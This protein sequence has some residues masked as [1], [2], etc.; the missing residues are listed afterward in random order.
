MKC[1]WSVHVREKDG[2]VNSLRLNEGIEAYIC[3]PKYSFFVGVSVSLRQ[4]D[5]SG[6]PCDEE[7]SI[8]DELESLIVEQL[9]DNMLCVFTSVMTA[10]GSRD[11][12]MYTYAPQQ[13]EKILGVLNETWSH[14]D[15]QFVFQEDPDWDVFKILLD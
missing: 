7:K 13:C 11:Y 14:H 9:V 10:E 2:V 15:I 8:L 12:I 4:V 3:H 1:E 6:L 5:E